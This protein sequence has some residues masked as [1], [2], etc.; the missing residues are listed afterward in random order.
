M[1]A[2]R[3]LASRPDLLAPL[4]EFL[5]G[6]AGPVPPWDSPEAAAEG[7]SGLLAWLAVQRGASQA[8]AAFEQ[9][10]VRAARLQ[11][12]LDEIGREL[13]AAGLEA[14]AFK[15]PALTPL[16]QGRLGLRP[17]G[18]LDLLIPPGT[19]VAV[20][21]ALGLPPLGLRPSGI[22]VDLQE[23]LVGSARIALRARAF[24]FDLRQ[25]WERSEPFGPGL[26]VL[27]AEHRFLHLAVHALKHGYSR[28]V[29][30][31]D[32]ALALPPAETATLP[33]LARRTGTD[34]A[35]ACALELVRRAF[36][37]PSP[38]AG[39]LPR[40][41]WIERA[42]VERTLRREPLPVPGDLLTALSIPHPL[43]RLLYPLELALLRPASVR[44]QFHVPLL[45]AWCFRM[46]H[47][48]RSRGGSR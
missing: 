3:A 33:A 2:T 14:L 23:D 27:D 24:R 13:Q 28:L 6:S 18:D 42:V 41:G 29:W 46:T 15:G 19:T 21:D 17:A 45:R 26:R 8:A 7:L 16:Y 48:L 40:L 12:E 1:T 39:E 9:H 44:R 47:L 37:R 43:W 32:L 38:L 20:R 36:G 22:L 31:L 25:V 11:A 10:F 30:I 5:R 35:A 4:R 34:R